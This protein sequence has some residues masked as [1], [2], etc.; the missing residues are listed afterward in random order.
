MS[1]TQGAE[2][3]PS[4]GD[5][6]DAPTQL[7]GDIP[8]GL[9]TPDERGHY[10]VVVDGLHPGRRMLIGPGPVTIGRVAPADIV[11]PD[12]ELSRAHCRVEARADEVLVTDLGSTNGTFVDGARVSG[13]ARIASGGTLRIGRQVLRHEMRSPREVAAA[14]HLESD[15]AA[16]R[17]YVESLLPARLTE[18]PVRTDWLFEPSARIGGDVLGYHAID[19]NHFALYLMDVAG[20]GASAALHA[21]SVMNVIRKQAL[22]AVNMREPGQVLRALNNMFPMEEHGDLFFSVMV[23]VCFKNER[24]LR[25]CSAGHHPGFLAGPDRRRASPLLTKNPVAGAQRGRDFRAAS[26]AVAPGST[27]YLFS[28]GLFE[29]EYANGRQGDIDDLLPLL[30]APAAAG[31]SEVRRIVGEVRRL[32]KRSVFDDDVTLLVVTF[33]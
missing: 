20:H 13:T 29:V 27:L 32:A 16:A 30:L 21:A 1:T 24:Q 28:D 19:E 26:T 31:A 25:Y 12:T 15:L 9:A 5:E 23:R 6:D 8:P 2:P 7:V 3:G 14:E 33:L 17:T 4:N 10:L 11:I 22:R 18:G